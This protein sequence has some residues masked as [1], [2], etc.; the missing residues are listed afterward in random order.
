MD[1]AMRPRIRTIKPEIWQDEKIGDLS[2]GARLLF[3]G[4]ITM[5]DDEGRLRELPSAILG[6]VF[7]YDTVTS[8]KLARWLAEITASGM[9]TRYEVGDK[10]YIA[11][12][13]WSKHQ[14]IDRPNSSELPAPFD[15]LSTIDRRSFDDASIP[16]RGRAVRSDP[17]PVHSVVDTSQGEV[18]E[19]DAIPSG[20]P[21]ELGVHLDAVFAVLCDLAARHHAKRVS[22]LSLANVIMARPRKPLVRAAH[23]FAA[24]ADGKA[25]RRSDTVAGYRNWLD[26][27][28]DLAVVES[29]P[30]ADATVIRASNRFAKYDEAVGL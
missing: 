14:K 23:D 8:A 15:D 25:Q 1:D 26:R 28:D 10:R 30:G 21:D 6:H 17:D 16:P 18:D 24:W 7:P 13:H 29:L 22:R 20:F 9:V 12:S 27:T 4:L 5:A 11:F 2:H 19:D 3:V